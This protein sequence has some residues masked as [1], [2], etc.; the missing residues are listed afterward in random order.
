[1]LEM[2]F[3]A[4]ATWNHESVLHA[5]IFRKAKHT[6][7]IT[8]S[9]MALLLSAKLLCVCLLS[10]L[11]LMS[12]QQPTAMQHFKSDTESTMSVTAQVVNSAITSIHDE[13][14]TANHPRRET[15]G[16]L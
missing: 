4:E 13:S 9:M 11:L 8:P 1:M 16:A 14:S 2:L 12:H 7:Q 15:N 5:D 3:C 10:A 6:T